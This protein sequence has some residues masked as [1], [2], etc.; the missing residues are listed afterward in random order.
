MRDG[1]RARAISVPLT[2]ISGFLGA[3]KTTVINNLLEKNEEG[4]KTG[5]LVNDFAE[6][7]IDARLLRGNLDGKPEE[8]TLLE[9][10]NGCVCC[11]ISGELQHSVEKVVES[12]VDHVLVETSGISDPKNIVDAL[13]L[14]Q[15][16]SLVWLCGIVV[17]VDGEAILATLEDSASSRNQ[18]RHADVVVLNKTDL[19][20]SETYEQVKTKIRETV[21]DLFNIIP[22]QYG[23]IPA[24][25]IFG[26][27]R[28]EEEKAVER[29]PVGDW[30]SLPGQLAPSRHKEEIEGLVTVSYS[31]KSAAFNLSRFQSFMANTFPESVI[32][33]KGILHFDCSP[34]RRY[35][36][37]LSG[38]RRFDAVDQEEEVEGTT[39]IDFVFIGSGLD[40]E[41]LTRD[42][43]H[44]IARGIAGGDCDD[45]DDGD[46]DGDGGFAEEL[47]SLI[48]RDVRFQVGENRTSVPSIV[49]FGLKHTT[50]HGMSRSDM[51][52][53]LLSSC[54]L[55]SSDSGLYFTHEGGNGDDDDGGG[56]ML[57]FDTASGGGRRAGDVW[58][59]IRQATEAMLTG[60]FMNT[61]CCG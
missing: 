45:D 49:F 27:S 7:N 5:L 2:I 47:S 41:G 61:F 40:R 29:D 35:T 26:I 25:V 15:L 17:V 11:T 56:F 51:N 52:R 39:G 36:L 38:K 12:G 28:K 10:S 13:L 3:G 21:P 18:L 44:C 57:R 46:G 48:R 23:N 54:N 6:L 16:R 33:A 59:G 30:L 19:L 55:R 43:D 9:L 8:D 53:A 1:G 4:V 20:S 58:R 42:L 24:S 32:R 60:V 50:W 22:S 14:P 31:R 34:T 37:Q